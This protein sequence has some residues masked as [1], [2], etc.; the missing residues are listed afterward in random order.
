M[1]G[2][3]GGEEGGRVEAFERS[4]LFLS[5]GLSIHNHQFDHSAA[6][7]RFLCFYAKC[8]LL[9]EGDVGS[10]TCAVVLVRAAVYYTNARRE[11]TSR[12]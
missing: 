8:L 12:R 7:E 11:P 3:G 6:T 1:I 9:L 5:L 4:P 10:S 2:G